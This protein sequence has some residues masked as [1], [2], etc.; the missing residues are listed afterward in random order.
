MGAANFPVGCTVVIGTK[1]EMADHPPFVGRGR[2]VADKWTGRKMLVTGHSPGGSVY[3][4]EEP[5]D[6]DLM[7]HPGR[8]TVVA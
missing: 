2:Q 6:L 8:L 7:V 4:G 5:G 1:Y 3:L